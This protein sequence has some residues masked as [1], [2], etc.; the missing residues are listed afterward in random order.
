M[1]LQLEAA[2]NY[3][4]AKKLYRSL[5]GL[6]PDPSVGEK[7]KGKVWVEGDVRWEGEGDETFIVSTL[8]TN[9]V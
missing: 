4:S 2:G 3:G 5:L 8:G 9:T 6:N 7:G 1:G